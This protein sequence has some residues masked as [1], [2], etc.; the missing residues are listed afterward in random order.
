MDNNSVPLITV[1]LPAYNEENS[2]ADTVHA[3]KEMYPGFLATAQE[4]GNKPAE[5]SIKN[6]LAVEEIHH[7]LYSKALEAVKGGGDLPA[8]SVYVCSVCGNTVE[9]D[10]PDTCPVCNVPGSKFAEV[11]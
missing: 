1:L 3:I 7:N 6:A 5:F 8:A 11:S 9:N 4:E 10:I 2:I